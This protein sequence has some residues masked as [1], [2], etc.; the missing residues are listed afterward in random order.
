MPVISRCRQGCL[1]IILIH[2]TWQISVNSE[3]G[4][5]ERHIYVVVIEIFRGDKT[6]A[7]ND[8]YRGGD[9]QQAGYFQRSLFFMSGGIELGS[10]EPGWLASVVEGLLAVLP[11]TSMVSN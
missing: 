8:D 9:G 3:M 6:S 1:E 2:E 5:L 10:G 7:N 11:L 4:L